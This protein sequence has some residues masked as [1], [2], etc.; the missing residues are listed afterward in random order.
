[1]ILQYF[2]LCQINTIV[3][4]HFCKRI[5]LWQI[6]STCLLPYCTGIYLLNS[7]WC[8]LGIMI[9]NNLMFCTKPYSYPHPLYNTF[10]QLSLIFTCRSRWYIKCFVFLFAHLYTIL[11]L[12]ENHKEFLRYLSVVHFYHF[13]KLWRLQIFANIWVPGLIT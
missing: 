13:Q 6:K 3:M 1:M 11:R 5:F 4:E 2:L 8:I 7:C 10:L 9:W 12:L